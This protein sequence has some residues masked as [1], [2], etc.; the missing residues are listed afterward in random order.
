MIYCII[1]IQF[2]PVY[3]HEVDLLSQTHDHKQEGKM[4]MVFWDVMLYNL[5]G[6]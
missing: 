2:L 3:V 5:L 1:K 4:N 6:G